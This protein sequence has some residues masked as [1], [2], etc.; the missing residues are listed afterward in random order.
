MKLIN[1]NRFYLNVPHEQNIWLH[2]ATIHHNL[3]EFMCFQDKTTQH[4]YI[5]EITGGTLSQIQDDSLFFELENYLQYN[6]I[7]DI[8]KP[9]LSDQEWL[10]RKSQ[11]K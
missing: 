10:Y 6:K 2:L 7:L 5:E 4:I 1:T 8:N 11:I 9:M 3:R